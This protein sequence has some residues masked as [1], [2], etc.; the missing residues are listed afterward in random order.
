[1]NHSFKIPVLVILFIG[2][3]ICLTSC[4][5][6]PTPPVVTTTNVTDIT[7]TTATTGG[8][9]TGDG[10]AKVTSRGVCWNTSEN[11]TIAN[12][13]ISDGTGTGSF[14]SSLTQLTPN[15]KYYVRA[16][17]TNSAGTGFGNQVSFTSNPIVLAT[18][19]TTAISNITQ[20]TATSGGNISNDGG[21]SITARGVCYGVLQ[22][23][24]IADSQNTT[25]GTGTGSFTSNLIGLYA[26][27]TY[28]VR[29]YA[30]N[31]VSTAYGNQI[32]FPTNQIV[33]PTLTTREI[34]NISTTS[35]TSGGTITNDGGGY[36]TDY[37]GICWSTSQNPTISDSHELGNGS[38]SFTAN[39]TGISPSTTYYVRAWATNSAGT[40]Y[41]NQ[42]SFTTL[43]MGQIIFNPN[44]TYGSVT[45]IDGNTYKTIQIGNQTWMAE[46]LKVTKYRD[47]TV[48][49]NVTDND[50]W[51]VLSSG[52]YCWY[53]NDAATNKNIYGAL[54]NWYAVTDTRNLCPAGWRVP[55][56]TEWT[57]LTTFLGGENVA[58]GK[59]KETGTT[60]WW[61]PNSGATNET[62]FTAL[63]GGE[64]VYGQFNNNGEYGYLW[65]VT[66]AGWQ[67][68]WFLNLYRAESYVAG[69]QF[70]K[71]DGMSVR[72]IKD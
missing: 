65:S 22:N 39:L 19:S 1:M 46:N 55:S 9:V 13:K 63:P 57:T 47:G 50:S 54:Y 48:I 26:G 64:N 4:K 68:A 37:K 67:N 72:C 31:G 20:T 44:L 45:D 3:I 52:A 21:A 43:E 27:T 66:E 7:Q 58:G 25:D 32:S 41:G 16:Y 69:G 70:G 28:Y 23:P 2:S 38:Y 40:G 62:G 59:L 49:P 34:T 51:K 29:A 71:E 36:V 15:T 17:A 5:D 12:S 33:V 18:L 35:A 56:E 14:T 30:T 42:V 61:I 11:P 53:N 10:G 60:H 8:N 6:D 24:T